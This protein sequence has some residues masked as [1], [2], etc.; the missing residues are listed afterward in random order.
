MARLIT[1]ESAAMRL[2]RTIASDILAYNDEKVRQGIENDDLFE[3]LADELEEG[4]RHF[5]E[6]TEPGI[7]H[8]LNFVDRAF[9]DAIAVRYRD[10]PAA[11]W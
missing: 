9:V 2:A 3:R 6:R 4:R 11:G 10:A 7:R 5:D 1:T 8:V